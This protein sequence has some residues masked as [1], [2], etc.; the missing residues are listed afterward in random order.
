MRALFCS[1]PASGHLLPLLSVARTIEPIVERSAA[2]TASA[3]ERTI[4]GAGLDFFQLGGV[5]NFDGRDLAGTLPQLTTRAP[6][7]DLIRATREFLVDC[8]PDQ[9]NCLSETLA[10]FNPDVVITD[11]M[12]FGV[13]PLLLYP[14]PRP[15]VIVCGTTILHATRSDKAPHFLGLVPADTGPLQYA[16]AELSRF[17]HVLI[18]EPV[19]NRLLAILE[20]L[21]AGSLEQFPY[22]AMITKADSYLQFTI[23]EFEFGN[24]S[25]DN[26]TFVGTPPIVPDLASVPDW[27][28][29]MDGSRHVV[30]VTQGTLA[31][32]NFDNIVRPTLEALATEGDILT[33]VTT[34]GRP[35][36]DVTVCP[37]AN[38][39]L[40]SYLP[41][42]W[43]LPK[44]N[45]LVTNGGYGTVNQ[46]LS[47]G[48]PI[49]AAGL[50]EDKRDVN[51]RI[52]WSGAGIDLRTN[53]PSPS[54]L[55]SSVRR[56]LDE[57]R[58]AERARALEAAFKRT[59]T[60]GLIRDAVLRLH[61]DGATHR[62]L[63]VRGMRDGG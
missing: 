45:V 16:Y 6:G 46:A 10:N 22:Q 28:G 41:F 52:E 4:R 23:P 55:R 58:F 27:A 19:Q 51:A 20:T 40:S 57:P 26:V 14:G 42:E 18:D 13:L 50:T 30:L 33:I 61:A 35:V 38:A 9:Y 53:R 8:I 12:F 25:T 32:H 11:D 17:H 54:V 63:P 15:R 31:N 36:D 34:G 29:D 5:A 44:V 37:P 21:Q 59:D 7:P 24:I 3:F 1:T 47:Y 39:R 2:L 49:V 56:L 62:A 43:L 48:I 60:E